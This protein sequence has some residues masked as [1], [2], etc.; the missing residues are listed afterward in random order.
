M[1]SIYFLIA[2]MAFCCQPL[3]FRAQT[4]QQDSLINV[5]RTRTDTGRVNV[6]NKLSSSYWY[7]DTKQTF[8][9]A[10]QALD[11]AEEIH[12]EQGKAAASNNMGAG[13]YQQNQYTEALSWYAKAVAS[14]KKTGNYR[15]EAFVTT[16]IGMIYWKRGEFPR[17][18]EYYLK[19]LKIWEDHGVVAETSSV[20]DNLGNIYNEQEQFDTALVYYQKSISIQKKYPKPATE[21]SMTLS[22]TGTAYLGKGDHKNALDYFLQSLAILNPEDKESRAVSLS[23]VGLTYIEMKDFPRAFKYLQEA[24]QLQS[25]IGDQ[26][27][28][29]H[30]LLGLA[31]VCIESGRL[32]QATV[33][34]N[35]A[36]DI[37]RAIS[38]RSAMD[39][40]WLMLSEIS[41]RSGDYKSA[42][43]SFKK[44]I[45][46]RDSIGNKENVFKIAKL[47]AGLETE[48]KQA[49]L[50]LLKKTTEEQRFR[51]NVIVA[52]LIA[53]LL[54]ASL[55]VSR[56]RLRIRKNNQLIAVNQQ[57]TKQAVQLEEQ[58]RTLQELDQMKSAFFANISHE[59]RTPLTLILNSL[60][61]K[62][63]SLSLS[64]DPETVRGLQIMDRN[65]KRLLNL[66]NQLLDLSKLEAGEMRLNPVD[67]DLNKFLSLICGSF[68]SLSVSRRIDFKVEL[69][70]ESQSVR[71]DRDKT[72]DI[73]YNLL[74]N[75][76]KFTPADG[77]VSF[78][79][80]ILN[81]T[82]DKYIRIRVSDSGPGVARE[83]IPFIFNRFYQG[84][85]YYA[86][87]QGTGIGLALTRE[88]VELQAG[89][90]TVDSQEG[91]GANFT[92]DLPFVAA[93]APEVF[94]EQKIMENECLVSDEAEAGIIDDVGATNERPCILVVEDNQD[95]REYIFTTLK[96]DYRVLTAE[97]GVRGLEKS[98]QIIPDLII[99][100]WM[101]PEMDGL[102]FC[103]KIREDQRTSHVPV[104]LLT[105]VATEDAR[106]RG[107]ETGADDYLTKPFDTRELLTRVRNLIET[108]KQLRDRFSR[109]LY[110]GPKKTIVSSMDEKFLEKVME[111]I[112]TFMGEPEFSMEKFGQEVGLSRMQLHRKLKALTG[113]SPGDFLRSM[114][115]KKAKRLLEA[116]AGNVSEIGYEV[117]FNNLSYFSKTYREEFGISPSESVTV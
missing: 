14:H 88:L 94:S 101:M 59:F 78:S 30:T 80:E 72:E 74:S 110:L 58:A 36:I 23:N 89:K 117:G 24:L 95:L 15:G 27:G 26:D 104:I 102:V 115:L 3:V 11:L 33:F 38:D 79:A 60:H 12:Y 43:E 32:K 97:N 6:L 69:P 44:H 46:A 13:Y 108:R 1:R 5:L 56:Q 99:S 47:Q 109:E 29:I 16:N 61:D 34:A 35:E 106:I 116:K 39:E 31:Q 48:R 40:A 81:D 90:I 92:V 52:G 86:D 21:I 76:F 2:I 103:Q 105:A 45:A 62:I 112:E 37:A 18:V 82:T 83:E 73:L 87:V 64:E 19:A 70:S 53:L 67:I 96:K 7:S 22:N 77:L 66:V 50:D 100:D 65:A 75:A 10:R 111:T 84:Q 57:L 54:I 4:A 8:I 51:R 25:E 114:R 17:A 85:R 107:L 20:Y 71:L 113:Q 98:M 9:Y 49:E 91:A 41:V 63:T 93:T 68:T 55:I 42:L 28:K